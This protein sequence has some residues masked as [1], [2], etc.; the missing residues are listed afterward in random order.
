MILVNDYMRNREQA[1]SVILSH[2]SWGL[3]ISGVTEGSDVGNALLLLYAN[4][5]KAAIK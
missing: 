4:D 3:L 5:I 1:N 2:S